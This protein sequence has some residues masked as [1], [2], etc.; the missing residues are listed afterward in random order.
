MPHTKK[1]RAAY[2]KAYR[3]KNKEKI[4]AKNK[5]YRE[6]NKEKIAAREKEYREK[7]K[8][9]IAALYKAYYENNKE[10]IAA[11]MKEY[12]QTPAGIKNRT[13]A[14]WKYKGLICEDV[15]SLYCHYLNATNCDECGVLF[16]KYGDGSGDFKTMDHSHSTGKFRNF[17][18]QKCNVKRGEH[19]L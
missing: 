1:K 17:L 3:E 19:N 8:E 18:C 2:D 13:L 10:K 9:R 14:D 4:A 16:G 5:E 6:K 12:N 11:W 15:D 7:N